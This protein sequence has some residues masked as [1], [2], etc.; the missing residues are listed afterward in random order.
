M[1]SGCIY[2]LVALGFVLI[3]KATEMVNF[4]QGD[5]M[6]LGAFIAFT[7][8]ESLG[9][10]YWIAFVTAVL[11]MAVFGYILDATILRQVLGQP[12][13][14]VVMLTIGLGF[15]FRAAASMIWGTE[16]RAF[17]TPFTG[18]VTRVGELVIANVN[19]S[20]IAGTAI[21]CAALYGF[22]RYTRIGVAM[23]A[24][25]QNQL[26]AY[27]MGIPVKMIFSLIWAISAG[28]AAVAGLLLAPVALI[29]IT[30]GLLGLKAFAAAVLGGFGSIPGAVVGGL[31]I[32]VIEQFSGV[33]LEEGL[34]DVAAY[35]VILL[36][37]FLRP[38]GLLGNIGRK[39]V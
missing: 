13:F 24:A 8:I 25:S 9:Y 12:Q 22:F 23:Q 38:Q 30:M 14:A 15:V 18:G 31:L 4:A 17:E 19:L 10:N 36:V 3:Y 34:K 27:Y 2:G 1:A 26:A 5:L 20:I 29:D 33:Y 39:R 37:L 11:F 28:V 21:L 32:G 16:T 35:I 6:M 7:V